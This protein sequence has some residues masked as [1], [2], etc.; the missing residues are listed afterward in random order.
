MRKPWA[1]VGAML[2]AWMLALA[3]W[4][5]SLA[6]ND[7]AHIVWAIRTHDLPGLIAT[8]IRL[9]GQPPLYPILLWGIQ[10]IPL[11]RTVPMLYAVGLFLAFPFYPLLFQ[12]A[13]TIGG[14]RTAVLATALAALNPFALGVM[15]FLRAYG[16]TLMLTALTLTLARQVDR[17]PTSGRAAAWGLSLLILFFTF[18]YGAFLG[19]A[20]AL[21]LLRRPRERARWRAALIGGG[22]AGL[23]AL[24]WAAA[25]LPR[26]IAIVIRH[27][28]SPGIHPDPL[29]MT[30]NAWLTLWSGWAADARFALAAGIWMALLLGA[31]LGM[32]RH[33]PLR[34]GFLFWATGLPLLGFFIGGAR[35]NFFAA[36][37]AVVAIPPLWLGIARLAAQAPRGLR[38][39]LVGSAGGIGLLGLSRVI[40]AY[41]YLPENNPWYT[42]IAVYL[43]EHAAPGDVVIAQAPWHY[44]ALLMHGPDLPW[45]LFDLNEEARWRAALRT[46]PVV[47]F[48]G[49]PA[50]R[51]NWTPVE[52]ALAGWI[53]EEVRTWPPPADAALIRYVPPAEAP[54][55]Q[56]LRVIFAGGLALEAAALDREGPPGILRVGLRIQALQPIPQPYT[57]FIHLLDSVGRWIAGSDGEPPIPT[58]ALTPG[59]P[60]TLWRTLEVP[61]WLP[62][63][64]YRVT[65]GWYPTG[66]GGWPRLPTLEGAD[67][68]LLGEI[69]LIPRPSLP[70]PRWGKPCGDLDLEA[71]AIARLA[72]YRQEGPDIFPEP[73]R[74]ERIR[75]SVEVGLRRDGIPSLGAETL[76][77]AGPIPLAPIA[78]PFPDLRYPAGAR[79]RWIYEGELAPPRGT[80][81]LQIACP[82]GT[83]RWP[84]VTMPRQRWGWNY[85]WILRN[86]MP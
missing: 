42:E 61:A 8:E 22:I 85:S 21:W 13:R 75:V 53:R 70:L 65:A 64:T 44:Q 48:L 14:D 26:A 1:A 33:N 63:G 76:T 51:G 68:A 4:R 32:S 6:H 7:E 80:L 46:R 10:Q 82:E 50:Y 38:A 3:L 16:L 35:Y 73:G 47:W 27:Q 59:V 23:A 79:A 56:P 57:L 2:L 84:A 77:D 5:P 71:V 83:A 31:S 62:P 86:R 34:P 41:A 74:S 17:R 9:D 52:T 39:L 45:Q 15:L 60:I 12:L 72:A 58:P 43:R 81:I 55:W 24:L 40:A 11:F 36:R 29:A 54:E 66:S 69:P 78:P 37:Y 19:V 18:Y 28:G 20:T 30:I 49:V 25:A 67:R